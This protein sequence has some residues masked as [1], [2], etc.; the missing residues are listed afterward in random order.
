MKL[1]VIDLTPEDPTIVDSAT[2]C[3]VEDLLQQLADARNRAMND[4]NAAT[5]RATNAQNAL[6]A[7][8]ALNGDLKSQV[9]AL[10][11]RI[12]M[13]DTQRESDCTAAITTRDARIA[14]LEGII[15]K[16]RADIPA[17]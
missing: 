10:N 12:T 7:A 4:V 17:K 9:E 5:E 13:G 11:T 14:E 1:L 6:D 15:E 3:S 16:L 8:N 2:R